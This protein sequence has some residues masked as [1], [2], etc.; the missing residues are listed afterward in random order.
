MEGT[1]QDIRAYDKHCIGCTR[2]SADIMISFRLKS[3]GEFHDI[4]LT[5]EQAESLILELNKKLDINNQEWKNSAI[6]NLLHQ[7]AEDKRTPIYRGC[8]GGGGMCFCTGRCKEVIG[9]ELNGEK[10]YLKCSHGHLLGS[11]VPC[12][13][14]EKGKQDIFRIT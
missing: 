5:T 2:N 9:Y 8:G 14:C 6:K 10:E 7:A 3:N 12:K 4:F 1:V 11:I 13:E